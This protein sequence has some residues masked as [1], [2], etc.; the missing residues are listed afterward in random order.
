[1]RGTGCGTG[2][3]EDMLD[4]VYAGFKVP[5]R[6]L[7]SDVQKA[8]EADDRQLAGGVGGQGVE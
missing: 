2:E 5:T 8:V 4:F 1:M 6:H 3:G 7:R